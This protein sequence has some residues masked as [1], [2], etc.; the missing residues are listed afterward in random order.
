MHQKSP[1]HIFRALYGKPLCLV[2]TKYPASIKWS[3]TRSDV[4]EFS[5]S[6]QIGNDLW[7]GTIYRY[8]TE[9]LHV[10]SNPASM[11][12]SRPQAEDKPPS[13]QKDKIHM[14]DNFPQKL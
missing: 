4:D 6:N 12:N 5:W 2:T 8:I 10:I 3:I 13:P 7:P 9:A 14:L 11:P 1:T